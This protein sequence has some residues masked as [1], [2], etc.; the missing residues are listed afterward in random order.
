[1]NAMIYTV[2]RGTLLAELPFPDIQ[3]MVR[4]K[5]QSPREKSA[6]SMSIPD[7]RDVMT[8]VPS[9]RATSVWDEVNAVF[10]AGDEPR[11]YVGTRPSSGLRE[12]L[13]VPPQLGRWFTPDECRVGA[14]YGPVV[15]GGKLWREA[16]RADPHILGTKLVVNGR[17]RTVVGVMPES[18]RF[19]E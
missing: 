5:A 4:V 8:R 13:G 14:E 10:A 6:F 11:R 15:L 3:R 7:V 2:V 16:F 17:P 19:P 9:L 12:A 18:F 1:V